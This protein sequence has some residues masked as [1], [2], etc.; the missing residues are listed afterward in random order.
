MEIAPD[1]IWMRVR[2][3]VWV[4]VFLATGMFIGNAV[5]G[6]QGSFWGG[7]AIASGSVVLGIFSHKWV[8][9]W[10]RNRNTRA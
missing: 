10:W 3:S 6:E 9:D 2:R 5:F 8:E 1:D 4:F 7:M